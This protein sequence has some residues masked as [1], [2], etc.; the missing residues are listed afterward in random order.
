MHHV[1]SGVGSHVDS[2]E[3]NVSSN[4]VHYPIKNRALQALVK[5]Q[6]VFSPNAIYEKHF[7]FL[8]RYWCICTK[9]PTFLTCNVLLLWSTVLPKE[10]R[11]KCLAQGLFCYLRFIYS[12]SFNRDFRTLSTLWHRRSQ[13]SSGN[14][15]FQ[16]LI[17]DEGTYSSVLFSF[18]T[19][20]CCISIS[21]SMSH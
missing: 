2:S 8:R 17:L 6:I 18:P 7:F 10:T 15:S 4:G 5:S 9:K 16:Y 14:L 19:V 3:S 21:H 20:S 1:N 13:F 12:V 11:I